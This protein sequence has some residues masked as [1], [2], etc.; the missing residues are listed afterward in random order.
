MWSS[1]VTLTHEEWEQVKR[2]VAEEDLLVSLG[3]GNPGRGGVSLVIFTSPP[4]PEISPEH[5]CS[6]LDEHL[7]DCP[8]REQ[9]RFALELFTPLVS[10]VRNR[11]LLQWYGRKFPNL[12]P[13]HYEY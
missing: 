10:S 3:G 7:P 2:Q 13:D 11:Q 5:I 9:E 6:I 1:N 4:V 12:D 8:R